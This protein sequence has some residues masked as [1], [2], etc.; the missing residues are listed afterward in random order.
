MK[1]NTAKF[2]IQKRVDRPMDLR[3]LPHPILRLIDPPHNS[4]PIDNRHMA[5]K[6]VLESDQIVFILMPAVHNLCAKRM[7]SVYLTVDSRDITI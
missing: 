6:F 2:I 1:I 5:I 7:R 3:I 4:L